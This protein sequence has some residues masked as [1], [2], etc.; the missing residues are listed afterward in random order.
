[1]TS[2]RQTPSHLLRLITALQGVGRGR[3]WGDSHTDLTK[4]VGVPQG[5]SSSSFGWGGGGSDIREEVDKVPEG[6]QM[7][8]KKG[9][10]PFTIG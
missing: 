1:M 4:Y 7:W 2:A 6:M 10:R 9:R 5:V 8:R 3:G